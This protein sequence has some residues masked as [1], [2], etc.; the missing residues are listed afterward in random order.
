MVV[1]YTDDVFENIQKGRQFMNVPY[2]D[3]QVPYQ[4]FAHLFLE[5]VQAQPEA[6]FLTSISKSLDKKTYTY[7]S[8]YE[9]VCQFA[10]VLIHEL[11]VKEN[12]R[13][14]SVAYNHEQTVMLMFACF[15]VGACYV[16]MNIGEDDER[17]AFVLNNAEVKALFVMSGEIERIKILKPHIQNIQYFIQMQNGTD[18]DFLNLNDLLMEQSTEFFLNNMANLDSE[19][20]LV[21][22]SG[23]T[24]TP[25]G[26]LLQQ[27]NCLIDAQEIVNWYELNSKDK[28][29]LVLPI[30]HVNGM[31]VTLLTPLYAGAS[32]VLNEKFS[33]SHY[34]NTVY[35]EKCTY[36][37]VVP[38]ILSFL[39]E[40]DQTTFVLPP[41]DYFLICGAG[42]L[43]V[44]TAKK[45]EE[46]FHVKVN[47]GYGLSETTCYSSYLP[48][49]LSVRE[50][51]KWMQSYGYPSIGV[52]LPCN[53]MDIHNVEGQSVSENEKGEIV[54][55]GHNVMRCYYGRPE[56]NAEAF[57]FG[58]FKS[59]DEG[60]YKLDE[61]GRQFF[62][63]TG[64]LKELIIRGGVNYSPLEIDE[65]I[66]Q[67]KGVKTG[68]AVGFENNMYGE[69]IGAYVV[70]E[71]GSKLDEAHILKNCE[72]LPYNKRPKVVIIGTDIP[73]TST[74]KYQRNKLKPLF[75]KWKDKQ[76]RIDLS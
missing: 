75:S 21:Y 74:G 69:E 71:K 23:T 18:A 32:V 76:F 17:M 10:N 38:T 8:F 55:R 41:K 58:W 16:P 25:K 4:N 72:S 36:G 30:H 61:K 12:D 27:Y 47:H 49:D 57:E 40:A 9:Q 45:F 31:I 68:I 62:F 73:V 24:G 22:T 3:K 13:V 39:C 19:A 35:E 50:Y 14:A 7:S 48:F 5:K 2:E 60:F 52:A 43:T 42:P 54:I 56:A 11:G 6:G 67:I 28:A 29:M 1:S 65:V 63:I 33:A 15:M 66:N 20:L 53:E 59:G 46:T 64:R 37:S 70:L 26:V 44:E 34:W 51:K